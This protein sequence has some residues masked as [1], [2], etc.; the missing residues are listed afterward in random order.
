MPNGGA[1]HCGGCIFNVRCLLKEAFPHAT[2][3]FSGTPGFCTLRKVL[4]P[5]TAYTYCDNCAYDSH[6][7][8]S[9]IQEQTRI[10]GSIWVDNR[11]EESGWDREPHNATPWTL[12]E[13]Q[14][15]NTFVRDK[16]PQLF[17]K[18]WLT[19]VTPW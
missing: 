14:K 17:T 16:Y 5:D 13:W 12:E 3:A 1:G 9:A 4:I 18:P 19:N 15:W 6:V 11:Y 7:D 10:R 2:S 8:D